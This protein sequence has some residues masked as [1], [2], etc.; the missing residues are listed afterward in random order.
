[1]PVEDERPLLE[2]SAGVQVEVWPPGR[3][4]GRVPGLPGRIVRRDKLKGRWV[5]SIAAGELLVHESC[6]QSCDYKDADHDEEQLLATAVGL[7]GA[8]SSSRRVDL[9]EFVELLTR[10]LDSIPGL[11]SQYWTL[12]DPEWT[13]AQWNRRYVLFLCW[14]H[15]K[16]V[17]V[18]KVHRS[19]KVYFIT[20]AYLP[21]C[22]ESSV[23]RHTRKCLK[24]LGVSKR[25]A[26]VSRFLQR[27]L[28]V[29]VEWYPYMIGK[30]Q[31]LI[32]EQV[33]LKGKDLSD[34]RVLIVCLLVNCLQF[35][36]LLRIGHFAKT[37]ADAWA[38]EARSANPHLLANADVLVL[39]NADVGRGC[40]P[41]DRPHSKDLIL[42][43]NEWQSNRPREVVAVIFL[44]WTMKNQKHH[45]EP[46]HLQRGRS[47]IEDAVLELLL[48]SRS[49]CTRGPTDQFTTIVSTAYEPGRR[50]LAK[51]LNETLKSVA[52]HFGF[53]PRD[54]SSTCNRVAGITTLCN[55]SGATEIGVIQLSGH[56]SF[57]TVRRHYRFPLACQPRSENR[58]AVRLVGATTDD[59]GIDMK[60]LE[61][62]LLLRAKV[63]HQ[64]L[65]GYY[66]ENRSQHRRAERKIARTTDDQLLRQE[67]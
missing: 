22:L 42:A 9:E 44:P 62:Q 31:R 33:K 52:R 26:V 49:F 25:E 36:S 3:E 30:A 20:R 48:L 67:S 14:V 60:L 45:V 17:D 55:A 39:V 28:P 10:Y 19:A 4:R 32:Q 47:E 37:E 63:R 2:L 59:C 35:A 15:L 54:W 43:I 27:R 65:L 13:Q 53:D 46:Y 16:G 51:H 34:T 41:V 6:I 50:V 56:A 18:E 38:G 5:V 12:D 7:A 1:M 29:A 40:H 57:S 24:A 11:G 61:V 58:Q 8:R 64:Q 23:A 21:L 66:S